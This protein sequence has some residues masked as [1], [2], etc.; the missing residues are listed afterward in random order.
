MRETQS[1]KRSWE[2]CRIGIT[3]ANG[4]LGK[5]LAK[6]LRDKGAYVIGLTHRQI[7]EKEASEEGPHEWVNWQCGEEN[8]L[9]KIFSNIDILIINHGMN[10]QGQQ[11]SHAINQALEVN[12]LSSIRLMEQYEAVTMKT[13]NISKPR[14]IWVNT[15]E[16]EIQPAL[17]PGYEISKRLIGQ[18]VSLRWS[19]L[20]PERKKNIKIRKLVLGP[21]FSEL[22]PIGVMSADFVAKQIINQVEFGLILIIVTPNPLTYLLI[23]LNE[24]CRYIYSLLISKIYKR[25]DPV[26]HHLDQ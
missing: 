17:S 14:E 6:K 3:G 16:A 10:P 23:P 13:Q 20:N 1:P 8:L 2:E 7:A 25:K 4:S 19:N 5:A 26:N 21:F 15:S 12:A 9:E 11:D 18:I 22:N 24:I